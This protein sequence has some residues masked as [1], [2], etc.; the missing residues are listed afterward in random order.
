MQAIVEDF[1]QQAHQKYQGAE[2]QTQNSQNTP[3]IWL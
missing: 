3:N 1:H 2:D